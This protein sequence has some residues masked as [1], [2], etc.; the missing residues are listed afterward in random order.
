MASH[1]YNRREFLNASARNAAGV[2]VGALGLGMSAN[3][4]E[5]SPV[6]VGM[7]GAGNRG[8]E[9][10]LL[11]AQQPGAVVTSLCDVDIRHAALLQ[12]ELRKA[13]GA[14]PVIVPDHEAMLSRSDVDA[15]VI[16]TPDHW[17]ARIAVEACQAGKDIYLEQPVA[18]SIRQG[19]QIVAAAK[20][21]GSLIQTGLPQRSGTHFVSAV[22]A[23]QS[24]AIGSIHF[25][26]AWAVH[27]RRPLALQE[28][29]T[30]PP[31]VDYDRWLGPAE[32]RPFQPSRFHQNWQ[33]FW[34]YGAG[35]L[36]CWGVQ[37]LDVVRWGLN[38]DL[39]SRISAS[40][41]C[42]H[43]QDQRETPDTLT[44]QYEFDD[45]Q[46]LWEH[47]QWSNHGIEGRTAGAAFY[48]SDGTLVI[49]RSGWKVYGGKQS[50]FE[51]ASE[52]RSTHIADFLE[53]IRTQ[54]SPSADIETGH[55]SMTL[56]HLGNIS[57]RLG[58]A[59]KFDPQSKSFLHD[60]EANQLLDC[61][62]RA[63]WNV[64]EAT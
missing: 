18:L 63:P 46:V 30:P 14:R 37:Y 3:A 28:S 2:A 49:D 59:L 29:S 7:I 36:G 27:Q 51:G 35:E 48:G 56:C 50:L 9:L 41:G 15:V 31:G 39:P 57:Y 45:V 11:F 61:R 4:A 24:G 38:L 34:D 26:K 17:H 12:D 58:R 20:Q 16:A 53:S 22:N 23:I 21:S 19:E 60:D 25:A 64:T 40:G 32:T 33:W 54:K 5:A 6:R 1:N 55:H 44:V 43:L 10:A 42:L 62:S 13:T 47:R 8:Q 52:I